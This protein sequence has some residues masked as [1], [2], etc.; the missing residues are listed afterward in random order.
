MILAAFWFLVAHRETVSLFDLIEWEKTSLKPYVDM[1]DAHA[2][3]LM[4]KM[5]RVKREAGK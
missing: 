4:N 1:L 5:R 2:I 3:G